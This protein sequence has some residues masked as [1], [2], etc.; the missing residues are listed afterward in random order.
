MQFDQIEITKGRAYQLQG[1]LDQLAAADPTIDGRLISTA[2]RVEDL[3]AVLDYRRRYGRDGWYADLQAFF[4]SGDH[5]RRNGARCP[6]GE[7]L[8]WAQGRFR[9]RRAIGARGGK[10]RAATGDCS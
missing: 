9:W 7:A 10:A 3:L 8:D 1:E 4:A 2:G 5:R 6:F